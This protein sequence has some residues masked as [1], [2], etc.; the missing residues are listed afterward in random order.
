MTVSNFNLN[1]LIE[2]EKDIDNVLAS[3]TRGNFR[4]AIVGY[5][6]YDTCNITNAT[7][8]IDRM[9]V[10]DGYFDKT[11]L[12]ILSGDNVGKRFAVKTQAGTT[13][14]FWETTSLTD[15]V[16]VKIFQLA[17][18]P[19]YKDFNSFVSSSTTKYSKS[20]DERI[21]EATAYQ[22]VYR[23]NNDMNVK[24]PVKDYQVDKASYQESYATDEPLSIR[25][26]MSP[27]AMDILAEL[28]IQSNA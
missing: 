16:A 4:P 12:E 11:V 21:K 13:L 5:T 17:K 27:Q 18:A 23:V 6:Q 19:F 8:S 24:Y 10:T 26:R 2:A 9:Q 28:T 1:T 22:Y 7:A 14:N 3:F 20:I 15:T 25:E